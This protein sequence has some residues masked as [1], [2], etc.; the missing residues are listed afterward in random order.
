MKIIMGASPMRPEQAEKRYWAVT[1]IRAYGILQ[2]LGVSVISYIF[3]R[4]SLRMT[5]MGVFNMSYD[6]SLVF[7]VILS[8]VLGLFCGFVASAIIFALATALDD[9]HTIRAYLRDIRITGQYYDE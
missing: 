3:L 9:L 2:I 5:L 6:A 8:I 1:I 4:P 7:A